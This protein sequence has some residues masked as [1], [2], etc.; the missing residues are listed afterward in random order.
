MRTIKNILGVK[1]YNITVLFDNNEKREINF[2]EIIKNFPVLK[3][4]IVFSTVSLDDYPTLKWDNLASIIDENG[5]K[6]KTALDFCPDT[7]YRFSK[8]VN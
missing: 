5:N 1:P 7:L 4:E 2:E 6:I 8:A 3:D